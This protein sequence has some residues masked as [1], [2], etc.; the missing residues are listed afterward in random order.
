[1]ECKSLCPLIYCEP[2]VHEWIHS[3]RL[4]AEKKMAMVVFCGFLVGLCWKAVCR[5]HWGGSELFW[6]REGPVSSH[7][8]EFS[9]CFCALKLDAFL[10]SFI[11]PIASFPKVL[12]ASRVIQWGPETMNP[13]GQSLSSLMNCLLI[14]RSQYWV[15][16]R[17]RKRIHISLWRWTDGSGTG[18]YNSVLWWSDSMLSTFSLEPLVL[19]S[20]RRGL[21]PEDICNL[22]VPC[23]CQGCVIVAVFYAAVCTTLQK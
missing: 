6:T 23:H 14:Y 5:E 3:S 7:V 17:E 12:Q 21:S 10:T 16:G 9:V 19:S 4:P 1:M 22:F 15:W 18:C 13:S 20:W 8:L 11:S 2:A